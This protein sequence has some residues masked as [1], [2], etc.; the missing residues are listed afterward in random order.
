[1]DL[2]IEKVFGFFSIRIK[3]TKISDI[4]LNTPNTF[5]KFDIL[6]DLTPEILTVTKITMCLFQKLLALY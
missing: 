6:I 4:V 3:T 1:M 5:L 2:R